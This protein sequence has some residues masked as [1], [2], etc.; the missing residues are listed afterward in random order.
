MIAAATG[1]NMAV[2]ELFAFFHDS[3]RVN[4]YTDHDHG[5][6]GAGMSVAR[7]RYSVPCEW[8][9]RRVSTRL[10]PNQVMVAAGNQ[11]VAR[12]DRLS[13]QG[14]TAYDWQHYIELIQRK[15]GALRNGAPF[16]DMPPVLLQLRQSLMRYPG[17]DRVMAD[18]LAVVPRSGLEAVLVAVAIALED[19]TPS[20]QVSIEHVENVL[21]RL[22]SPPVPPLAETDLQLKEAPRADTARYDQLRDIQ[23]QKTEI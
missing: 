15:P 17:G 18:I 11:I 10:Y 21:A 2:V 12:H 20:G 14:K 4:E 1:A 19:V 5:K 9:N 7:N 6:R 8:A 23:Q 16:L 13:S 22:N 3:C